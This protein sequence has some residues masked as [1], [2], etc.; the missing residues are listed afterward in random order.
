MLVENKYRFNTVKEYKDFI[1]T[2]VRS[3]TRKEEDYLVLQEFA[4]YI[5]HPRCDYKKAL[6]IYSP[7]EA[8]KSTFIDLL[9]QVA[10]N[11]SHALTIGDFRIPKHLNALEKVPLNA[12]TCF[13]L[14][15]VKK[16][17][18]FMDIVQGRPVWL[19]GHLRKIRAK[20]AFDTDHLDEHHPSWHEFKE[21][22]ILVEFRQ[23]FGNPFPKDHDIRETIQDYNNKLLQ[24]A[25]MLW[26]LEG[27]QRLLEQDGFTRT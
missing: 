3:Y 5:L 27:L 23:P 26:A 22:V 17:D 24:R 9:H 7:R 2:V 21:H 10:G 1:E 19:R 15:R 25:A 16:L 6:L 14:D 8:G 11:N 13:C 4:G 12:S 18:V 20:I